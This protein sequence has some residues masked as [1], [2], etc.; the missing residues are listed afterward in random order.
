MFPKGR[1]FARSNDDIEG[2]GESKKQMT[3]GNRLYRGSKL[4]QPERRL[5]YSTVFYCMN[6]GTTY[7]CKKFNYTAR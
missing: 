5:T 6:G 4:P 3:I 2:K 7:E 1:N